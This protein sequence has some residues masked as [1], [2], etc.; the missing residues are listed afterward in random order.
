MGKTRQTASIVSSDQIVERPSSPCRVRG[1]CFSSP[2][3]WE[4]FETE[5][6]ERDQSVW[7]VM[8]AFE[9]GSGTDRRDIERRRG[10]GEKTKQEGKVGTML[11]DG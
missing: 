2:A 11:A 6:G 8:W 1:E 9:L 10:I 3:F 7:R 5:E 4:S